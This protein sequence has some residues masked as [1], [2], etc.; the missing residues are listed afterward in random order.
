MNFD[1]MKG[2]A[3]SVTMWAGGVL[4]ALGQ[5]A[6]YVNQDMLDSIGIQGKSARISLTIAALVMWVCRTITT[7]SLS[8]KGGAAPAPSLAAIPSGSTITGDKIL[9]TPPEKPG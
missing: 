4:L 5:V 9:V 3:K 1:A 2:A 7:K 6:P 8:E